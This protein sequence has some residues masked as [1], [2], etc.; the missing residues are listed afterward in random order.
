MNKATI[1]AGGNLTYRIYN[2]LD[3]EN[4]NLLKEVS[5]FN[6]ITQTATFKFNNI[7]SP[8]FV[9]VELENEFGVITSEII[10]IDFRKVL[11]KD[12]FEF[13]ISN[14]NEAIINSFKIIYE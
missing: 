4:W 3:Q 13:M 9:K 14:L 5:N 2:S 11:P 1:Y 8:T 10:K 6:T 7:M 12:T